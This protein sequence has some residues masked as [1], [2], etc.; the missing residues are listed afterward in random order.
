MTALTFR[1]VVK[2]FG[3]VEVLHGVSFELQREGGRCR[4]ASS[5]GRMSAAL[6]SELT[7]PTLKRHPPS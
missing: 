5:I 4:T 1:D 6:S 2:R 7:H 3:A